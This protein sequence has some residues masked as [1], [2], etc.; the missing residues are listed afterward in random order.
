[1]AKATI[2]CSFCKKRKIKCSRT[3]PCTSCIRFRNPHCDYKEYEGAWSQHESASMKLAR[4][5]IEK[6]D[7]LENKL[8]GNVQ[9]RDKRDVQSFLPRVELP[10]VDLPKVP[11][12]GLSGGSSNGASLYGEGSQTSS[13]FDGVSGCPSGLS[14]EVEQI[15]Q[16]MVAEG[17]IDSPWTM[18]QSYDFK[19]TSFLDNLDDGVDEKINITG[20]YDPMVN[21][22][23]YGV[24]SWVGL[25][26]LDPELSYIN[27]KLLK[28]NEEINLLYTHKLS[29]QIEMKLVQVPTRNDLYDGD[30]LA[31]INAILPSPNLIW[32]SINYF[33][34]R[35]YCFIPLLDEE[36][37]RERAYEMINATST[38]SIQLIDS[39]SFIFLG[40]LLL[41]MRFVYISNGNL[42]Y[43]GPEAFDLVNQCIN[44]YNIF[45]TDS[46]DFIQLLVI[47]KNYELYAPEIGNSLDNNS[48]SSLTSMILSKACMLKMNRDPSIL[49]P[50]AIDGKEYN[51]RRKLWYFFLI[52]ESLETTSSGNPPSFQT[53]SWSTKLPYYNG[54]NSNCLKENLENILFPLMKNARAFAY[55]SFSTERK[56]SVSALRKQ[57]EEQYD[58]L[59]DNTLLKDLKL[60][61]DETEN[62]IL[63]TMRIK[64]SYQ[65]F[66]YLL[67]V[68]LHVFNFYL[69]KDLD[70][71]KQTLKTLFTIIFQKL[72]PMVN[73][74]ITEVFLKPVTP[75]QEFVNRFPLFPSTLT[76]ITKFII[77][78]LSALTK[79]NPNTQLNTALSFAS[80]L[81]LDFY[82]KLSSVSYYAWRMHK[83]FSNIVAYI[84]DNNLYSCKFDFPEL[85][86]SVQTCLEQFDMNEVSKSRN[87][88]AD[89]NWLHV[90]SQ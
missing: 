44:K 56:I 87:Y 80:E 25:L 11:S 43:V 69:D 35:V 6:V 37:F 9:S 52:L 71:V 27:S 72:V 53:I 81:F 17:V 46:L 45:S 12:G 62:Y 10:R 60:Q 77:T 18:E 89:S 66:A 14:N 83:V 30:L 58:L 55:T 34:E 24:Y 3:S 36:T 74:L 61:H 42:P 19:N 16:Q 73:E 28:R 39:N 86:E 65:S 15:L 13:A 68:Y 21:G 49:N 29:N 7:K 67:S 8:V 48:S 64:F 57:A 26:S 38:C 5:L 40:Q 23:Y 1:M 2:V 54:N 75:G 79:T 4:I 90:L 51:L 22:E 88:S 47:A 76:L 41:V 85:A 63:K 50:L 33:F 78:T 84:R 20:R 59:I 31:K 82:L 70:K 32:E